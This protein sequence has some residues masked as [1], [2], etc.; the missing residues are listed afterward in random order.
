M[1]SFLVDLTCLFQ[2]CNVLCDIVGIEGFIH[3]LQDVDP[4]P[5]YICEEIDHICPVNDHA[6]AN[7][8][9]LTVQPAAGPQG[10]TFNI[11]AQFRV[12]NTIGTGEAVLQVGPPNGDGQAFGDGNLLVEVPPG[13]YNV[14]AKLTANPSKQEPYNPGLFHVAFAVC[15]GTCGSIHPHTYLLSNKVTTF[16]IN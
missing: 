2:V 12:S 10:T 13:L 5:I 1:F 11:D 4:D 6:K 16:T 7:I 8:T 15:E 14:Q 3:L 9:A